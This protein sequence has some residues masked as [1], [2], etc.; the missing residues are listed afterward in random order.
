MVQCP[1]CIGGVRPPDLSSSEW[2]C[3]SCGEVDPFFVAVRISA[4]I[5]SAARDRVRDDLPLWCLWPLLPGWTVTGVG[6]VGD[7]RVRPRATAVAC[8][9]PAPLGDGPADL[10]LVAE[11]P[12][13]GLGAGLAGVA[14]PDPG[15]LLT[16]TPWPAAKVRAAGHPT[17]LW[18]VPSRDDRSAYAGEAKGLWLYAIVWPAAAGYLLADQVFLQDLA[19]RLPSEL[20]FGA[21]SPYLCGV[22]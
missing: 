2:R 8:S 18:C 11:R 4:D 20:V 6:W 5:L 21:P 7:D 10:V 9:G 22:A 13:T 12:G 17:P 3:D 1:R 19:D 16:D 14:G 15:P